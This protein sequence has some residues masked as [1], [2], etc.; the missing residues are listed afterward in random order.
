L[1]IGASQ[2]FPSKALFP[3]RIFAGKA[4]NTAHDPELWAA[5]AQSGQPFLEEIMRESTN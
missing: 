2:I 5:F 1:N 3:R 4:P